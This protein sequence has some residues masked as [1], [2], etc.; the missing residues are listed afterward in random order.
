MERFLDLV[1]F[2]LQCGVVRLGFILFVV[3]A[4]LVNLPGMI[5]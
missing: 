2:V 3:A 5:I 4:A 1:A